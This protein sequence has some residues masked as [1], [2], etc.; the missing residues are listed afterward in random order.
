MHKVVCGSVYQQQNGQHTYKYKSEMKA[1]LLQLI[2]EKY[3]GSWK[4]TVSS[5]RQQIRNLEISTPKQQNTLSS[6]A[7]LKYSPR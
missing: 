7:H 2:P 6:Q 1:V 4:T 3:K 5:Y